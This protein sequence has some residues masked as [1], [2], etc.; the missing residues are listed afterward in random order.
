MTARTGAMR[1]AVWALVVALAGC[2]LGHSTP[3][4]PPAPGGLDDDDHL[5]WAESE[6]YLVVVRKSCRKL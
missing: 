2:G 1:V 5:A 6:Q 4:P 3:A